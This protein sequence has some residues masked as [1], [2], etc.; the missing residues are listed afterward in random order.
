MTLEERRGRRVHGKCPGTPNT[1]T[2]ESKTEH[3]KYICSR[4]S[5]TPGDGTLADPQNPSQVEATVI[6]QPIDSNVSSSEAT[7]CAAP[8]G[9]RW[10]EDKNK[11]TLKL[12]D[13][14]QAGVLWPTSKKSTPTHEGASPI[15]MAMA[16]RAEGMQSAA[17]PPAILQKKIRAERC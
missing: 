14:G 10:A 7:Q 1:P 3:H 13:M 17:A 6:P 5:S 4:L 16:P 11:T 8:A 12:G 2:E 15:I 9:R